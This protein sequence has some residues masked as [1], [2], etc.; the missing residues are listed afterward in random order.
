MTTN[1]PCKGQ[2]IWMPVCRTETLFF[3]RC[4]YCPA[5]REYPIPKKDDH[6]CQACSKALAN[7]PLS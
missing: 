2:H 1:D 6:Y 3:D 4:F 5:T 7:D